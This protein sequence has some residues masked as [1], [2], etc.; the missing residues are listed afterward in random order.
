M[1][2]NSVSIAM[3]LYECSGFLPKY[4]N[5]FHVLSSNNLRGIIFSPELGL[6][7]VEEIPELLEQL[8]WK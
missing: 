5:P 7:R 4:L 1:V 6:R 8:S 2:P 3:I